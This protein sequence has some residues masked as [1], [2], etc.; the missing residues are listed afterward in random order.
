MLKSTLY[1]LRWLG[2]WADT[3]DRPGG[4]VRRVV[5]V[6]ATRE[7]ERDFP[8]WLYL[9][10]H[11]KI[12]GAY[13]IAP[14]LHFLGPEDPRMDRF[15][16]VL[17]SA[18]IAIFAPFV[19]DYLSLRIT[20]ASIEDFQRAFRVFL[21]RPELP[22]GMKP[23]IWS[24]SSGSLLSLRLASSPEFAD[25]V[26]GVMS[27]GGYGDWEETFRFCLT[28]ELNGEKASSHDPLN[29]PVLFLQL[30]DYLEH[31]LD[32]RKTLGKG[33]DTFIRATWS[34]AG[35][36]KIDEN[37]QNIARELAPSLPEEL[38][39]LFLI[40][41][42]AWDEDHWEIAWETLQNQ[43]DFF[44]HMDPRPYLKGIQCPVYLVH[45]AADDVIPSNQ[46]HKIAEHIPSH[47]PVEIFLTGLYGHSTPEHPPSP[48]EIAR[49]AS[50]EVSTL[51]GMTSAL[52]KA[53]M[54]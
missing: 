4:V 7:G 10:L 43:R 22:P 12:C 16:S 5:Q 2:P 41:C 28:G 11:R 39:E 23:G 9:P 26:G 19:P 42:G 37:Y 34:T 35:R 8:A 40:G 48:L 32:L 27:Y 45:G 6:R 51:L 25:R 53:A 44:L 46:V 47:V 17:S 33:W 52:L 30:L 29:R 15:L 36:K 24:I 20:P 38:R 50:E 18:G 1:L 54:G 14:G 49:D 21:E 13:I 3:D 31:D